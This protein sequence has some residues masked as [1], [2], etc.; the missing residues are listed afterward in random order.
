MSTSDYGERR[1]FLMDQLSLKQHICSVCGDYQTSYGQLP[2][3]ILVAAD[4][5]K[6]LTERDL[7]AICVQQFKTHVNTANR[8]LGLP[9]FGRMVKTRSE[10]VI[11]FSIPKN[12]ELF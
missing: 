4:V 12:G 6:K 3:F 7:A 8:S 1:L 2:D 10:D 11:T 5:Y 9:G